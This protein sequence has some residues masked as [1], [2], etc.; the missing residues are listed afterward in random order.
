MNIFRT[1]SLTVFLGLPAAC[2]AQPGEHLDE[3]Q[4]AAAALSGGDMLLP[5]PN[6]AG[7]ALTA[8]SS[9]VIDTTNPFF[10]ALGTNGRSCGSCHV[11]SEG[12]SITPSGLQS[13]FEATGGLDPVFRPHD[14]AVSPIADVSSVEARRAA[15]A[16]LLSRGLVRVGL[17]VKATSEFALIAIDDPYGWASAAQLSLFRRPLP[18]TNLRFLTVINWDGRN[19]PTANP[20]DIELGLKN[21]ANG[22]TVNHA[23]AASPLSE[24]V[25]AD[26]VRFEVGLVTAQSK[27]DLAGTLHAAR[28]RGGPLALLSEPFSS[29]AN[30]P[31][32]PTFTTKVFDI[33]DPWDR[34]SD[35][36][37]PG[38]HAVADGERIF[39]EKV[40]STDDGKTATCSTCHSAPNVGSSSSVRYAD[41]G[42][43]GPE[44]R[45]RDVPLYTFRNVATGETIQTTDPGRALISGAWKDMNRFKVP[46]LRA[47]A[48][49]P[50]YFHDG[51]AST[52]DQVVEHY[53]RRFGIELTDGEKRNLVAFLESL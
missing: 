23:K 39:N 50:P 15:Y 24:E 18:T 52:I 42:V 10:R 6:D 21:Q 53:R 20:L 1:T 46:S 26:I 3:T 51:S 36:F 29:G 32:L 41:V 9:G 28:A 19:T 2:A 40:F 44:R 13:R 12:W 31:G 27:H 8:T 37:Q 16:L 4:T 47:L 49:R 34:Y 33:Y 7:L 5:Q 30:D 25:R 38:R 14:V 45:R 17:P 11:A 48:A 35:W 43:S 22:A